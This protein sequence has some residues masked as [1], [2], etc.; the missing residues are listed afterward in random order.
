MSSLG[1]DDI[2]TLNDHTAY[3]THHHRPLIYV[4]TE[5]RTIVGIVASQCRFGRIEWT[6]RYSAVKGTGR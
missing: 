6:V 1:V 4:R 3:R 2:L 5:P